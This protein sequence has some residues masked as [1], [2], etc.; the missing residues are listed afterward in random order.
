MDFSNRMKKKKNAVY[1]QPVEV[2]L[3]LVA[4][5]NV[6]LVRWTEDTSQQTISPGMSVPNDDA[7]KVCEGVVC[8]FFM[9][10]L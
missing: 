5:Q 8:T 7:P 6:V 3:S 10:F 9:V 1:N 4:A 2:S